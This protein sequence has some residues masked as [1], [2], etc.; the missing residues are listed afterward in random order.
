M[1]L[2]NKTEQAVQ[3][4]RHPRQPIQ[5]WGCYLNSQLIYSD[6][7]RALCEWYRKQ[8]NT[9]LIIKPVTE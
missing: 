3:R 9:K 4:M 6:A 2:L 1:K 5:Q 8:Y 7:K